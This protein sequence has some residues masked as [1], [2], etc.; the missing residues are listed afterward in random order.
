MKRLFI[1]M[2]S[3]LLAVGN[4]SAYELPGVINEDNEKLTF[5]VEVEGEPAL[6]RTQICSL[7]EAT[8][9][10][11]ENQAAVMSLIQSEVSEKAE[12]EF[13]Y[14]ALF[15]GFSMEANKAD[16]DKIKELPGVKNVYISQKTPVPEITVNNA[17]GMGYLNTAYASGYSGK[18][19]VIAVIDSFCDTGHDFFATAPEDAKYTKKDIDDILKSKTLNSKV[20]SANQVYKSEKIPYAYNY[21]SNSSDTFSQTQYHGTHVAGIAVGKDGA[22]PD[23]TKFS[24][25]AYDAQMLFMSVSENG[26]IYD[27]MVFAAIND[28]SLLGADVI[29]MSFGSNYTDSSISS[30]YSKIVENAKNAGISIAAA[31]GNNSKGYDE[32]TPLTKNPDYSTSGTPAGYSAITAVASADNTKINK[33]CW[34]F[35]LANGDETEFY[36]AYQDSSFNKLFE[37]DFLEYVYCGLGEK[38]DFSNKDLTGKIALVDRGEI[39]FT[40]KS[41]NA[42]AAGAEGLIIANTDNTIITLNTLSLPTAIVTNDTG[43]TLAADSN[44]KI[45]YVG[46]KIGIANISGADGISYYSGWGVDSSLELKPEITAPG[47]NIYSSYPDNKYVYASGTSMASPYMAGVFAVARQYYNQNPFSDE[48]NGL[49]GG[50]LVDLIENLAMSTADII[51]QEN[52]VAYSPRVQGSGLVNVKKLTESK[53]LLEGNSGKAKV[54]MGEI[55][56]TF[57]V[58]FKI[59]NIS[60]EE[61][62]FNDVS[63]EVMADGYIEQNGENYVGDT[64]E[65]K[66]EYIN[67]PKNVKL[68]PGEDYTFNAKIKL[69][70]E[71]IKK[72]KKI[73]NNGFFV[74]GFV[75]LKNS[76][77]EVNVSIP[78]TGFCGDWYN[79]PIFD[80]TVY[81]EG[82]SLLADAKNPYTTGTYLKAYLDDTSYVY[83]GRNAVNNKIADK[84]YISFSNKAGLTLA[85]TLKNYRTVSKHIFSVADKNNNTLYSE[86]ANGLINKFSGAT[87]KFNKTKLSKLAEG[88]YT[89]KIDATANGNDAINDTLELPIVIDNTPPEVISAYYNRNN[90]I[91]TVS[92]KDNHYISYICLTYKTADGQ[93]KNEYVTV[94]DNDI[95]DGEVIKSI[96]MSEAAG[97]DD[98]KIAFCDYAMNI[99]LKSFDELIGSVEA[100]IEQI[101]C[102]NG[103]TNA[104]ISLYN[105]TGTD[106]TADVIIAFYDE[107][108]K[109]ISLATKEDSL[110]K[111]ND[112]TSVTYQINSDITNVESAKIFLWKPD[113]M[114][115][116]DIAK[117]FKLVKQNG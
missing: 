113:S 20:S 39:N 85:L 91:L 12:T 52:G 58:S 37:D 23:G 116:A 82:G 102:Q 72:Y 100:N 108:S 7:E 105:N 14:T 21:A 103:K 92:A 71:F 3:L 86:T 18:G 81:D 117:S 101:I 49:S 99:T 70:S 29:N 5:I 93:Q 112:E 95:V 115:P 74:D 78:F 27:N 107:N 88:E 98:I 65:A 40:E 90:K 30:A 62:E 56:D 77:D 60:K 44:K 63:V 51:R 8:D 41:D 42:K 24:G 73:F 9:E 34:I 38:K 109:L 55:S 87:Y 33:S 84:K 6:V 17:G 75:T 67:I 35:A 68:A 66:T 94:T 76:G 64:I 48:Y 47:G 89:L 106:I 2:L 31:A 50:E 83:V 80:K 111:S 69:D 13:V 54:S 97:K 79:L 61:V 45:K 46:N 16:L 22:L 36:A 57:E 26:Y 43:K 110:I 11:L 4:V 96:S 32:N 25:I 10:I 15:N 114:I 59:T 1:V 53:V 28:A 19:Q 104:K